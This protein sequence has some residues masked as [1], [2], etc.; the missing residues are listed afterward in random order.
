V[1][2]T[3]D[4]FITMFVQWAQECGIANA[5]CRKLPSALRRVIRDELPTRDTKGALT[6]RDLVGSEGLKCR[7]GTPS[8]YVVGNS[9]DDVIDILSRFE[10]RLTHQQ[11]IEERLL[12]FTLMPAWRTG[13]GDVIRDEQ[14]Y[15]LIT[16]FLWLASQYVARSRAASLIGA[17]AFTYGRACDFRVGSLEWRHYS[18]PDP[19][20]RIPPPPPGT[21]SHT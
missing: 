1:S 4:L 19:H 11:G 17:L 6:I 20:S 16:D 14:L 9:D 12:A 21:G 3:V 15:D 18:V 10:V 13:F 2:S 5:T 8:A 7:F